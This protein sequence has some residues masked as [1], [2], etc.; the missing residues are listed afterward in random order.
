MSTEQPDERRKIK[1]HNPLGIAIKLARWK[2]AD[3]RAAEAAAAMAEATAGG[4]A[5]YPLLVKLLHWVMALALLALVPLGFAMKRLTLPLETTFTL[6][7]LHRSLGVLLLVSAVICLLIRVRRR[8][9]PWPA[10]AGFLAK[11]VMK[12][13]SLALYILAIAV[14]VSGWLMVSAALTPAPT[15]VFNL[16]PLPHWAGL[17][18]LPVEARKGWFDLYRVWHLRLGVAMAGVA[19]LHTILAIRLGRS[20]SG[21][22]GRMMRG[23][24]A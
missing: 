8:A 5:T 4:P 24:R 2:R 19:V 16:F 3:K 10:E 6:Q 14:A 9:P 18:E 23:A 13:S 22:V 21:F 11:A 15:R 20:K 12:L 7:Q 17:A 1:G